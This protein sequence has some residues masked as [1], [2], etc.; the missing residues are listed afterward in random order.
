[1]NN[2]DGNAMLYYALLFYAKIHCTKWKVWEWASVLSL[3]EDLYEKSVPEKSGYPPKNSSSTQEYP[4]PLTIKSNFELVI[5]SGKWS[6]D[7][8]YP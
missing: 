1:M 7:N 4:L 5:C 6:G 3:H 2:G 8:N